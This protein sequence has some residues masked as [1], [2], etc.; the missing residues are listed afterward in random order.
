MSFFIREYPN[1]EYL[2]AT[3]R[4]W[5]WAVWEGGE[6]I[7]CGTVQQ[8][9]NGRHTTHA[10][11]VATPWQRLGI[12]SKIVL[13]AL[14]RQFGCIYS[15]TLLSN[16]AIAAWRKSGAVEY[17]PLTQFSTPTFSLKG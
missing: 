4:I 14:A 2:P 10:A 16:G 17:P 7:A 1:P 3:C 12:Y 9:Y 6:R 15:D 13:P 8:L 5:L 11:N